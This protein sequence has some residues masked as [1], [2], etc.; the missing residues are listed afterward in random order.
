MPEDIE[1]YGMDMNV[2]TEFFTKNFKSIESVVL[3][4]P[5]GKEYRQLL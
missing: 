1:N 3:V 4:D 2:V 5:E